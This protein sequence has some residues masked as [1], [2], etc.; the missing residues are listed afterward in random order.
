M[1]ILPHV[2]LGVDLVL[3]DVVVHVNVCEAIP[4]LRVV[5]IGNGCEGIEKV[6]VHL[7]VLWH[8]FPFLLLLILVAL[9]HVGLHTEEISCKKRWIGEK[10]YTIAHTAEGT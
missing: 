9:L 5:V 4:E 2:L 6:R 8:G 3:I 7:A 10:V 1:E